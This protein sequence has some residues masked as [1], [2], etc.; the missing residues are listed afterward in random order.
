MATVSVRV[1]LAKATASVRVKLAKGWD[2]IIDRT[3]ALPVGDCSACS[4]LG[5]GEIYKKRSR[6][7]KNRRLVVANNIDLDFLLVLARKES[8]LKRF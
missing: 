2:V 7:M 1:K 5:I 4:A 6:L 8:A 3:D